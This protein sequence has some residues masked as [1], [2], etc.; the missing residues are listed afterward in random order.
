MPVTGICSLSLIIILS[1]ILSR[2]YYLIYPRPRH[3]KQAI[4]RKDN[5]RT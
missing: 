3:G 1:I 5:R 2:I 4:E